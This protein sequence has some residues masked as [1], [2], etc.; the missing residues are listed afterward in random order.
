MFNNLRFKRA[1]SLGIPPISWLN[2]SA[3]LTV[4]FHAEVHESS[5]NFCFSLKWH[6]LPLIKNKSSFC[7]TSA[8]PT[9]AML[10]VVYADSSKT[11]APTEHNLTKKLKSD[12]AAGNMR[13]SEF[14]R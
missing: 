7:R 9:V 6:L 3:A 5:G 13:T 14:T 8:D 1:H 11:S 10:S 2:F 12:S 4:L